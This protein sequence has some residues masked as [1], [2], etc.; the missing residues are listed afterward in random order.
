MKT[1]YK[2]KKIKVY[3][4][5]SKDTNRKDGHSSLC[6]NCKSIYSRLYSAENKERILEYK[7]K[8]TRL[9]KDRVAEYAKKYHLYNINKRR[10]KALMKSYGITLNQYD[11][12]FS[13]QNGVCLICN[14]PETRKYKGKLMPLSV[15]HS[16]KTEEVRGLLCS[17][18]N[19]GIGYFNDDPGILL[20]AITYLRN[21]KTYK[22]VV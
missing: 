4:D 20:Q 10:E 8:W 7:R 16:H 2:C 17:N 12:M 13:N 21:K 15:D 14:E 18:C 3:S 11:E 5:F 22:L 9:N 6:R 19:L 1:C